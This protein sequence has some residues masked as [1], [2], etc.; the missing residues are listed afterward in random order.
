MIELLCL[1]LPPVL[2][3]ALI[4]NL[5]KKKHSCISL[6]FIYSWECLSANVIVFALKRFVFHQE[7]IFHPSETP[8]LN[9]SV[10]TAFNYILL[11]TAAALVVGL[12]TAFI[13]KNF[14]LHL[15][16]KAE[17]REKDDE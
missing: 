3:V 15:E 1:F 9:I 2:G 11:G 17:K 16:K 4:V 8:F 12:F 5:L 10:N 6:I 13:M 14:E 7:F